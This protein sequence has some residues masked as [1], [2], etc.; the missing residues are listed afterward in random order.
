MPPWWI[1]KPPNGR[2]LGLP[3]AI[4]S[5]DVDVSSAYWTTIATTT[6]FARPQQVQ[7]ILNDKMVCQQ[8]HGI[9]LL[10]VVKRPMYHANPNGITVNLYGFKNVGRG[11][12]LLCAP[13]RQTSRIDRFDVR[14]R[15]IDRRWA[16]LFIR[17]ATTPH[18]FV[19][20]LG[21]N[22][23]Q[24]LAYFYHPRKQITP[25]GEISAGTAA[26]WTD[27]CSWY[28]RTG[29]YVWQHH[30]CQWKSTKI[31]MQDTRSCIAV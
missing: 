31:K 22:T 21:R 23:G 15:N 1:S 20:L 18:L 8:T 28:Y 11:I 25:C 7:L 14:W 4:R 10:Q 29:R 13:N 17:G 9:A 12:Q 26:A 24:N 5:F 6:R 16:R 3:T 19:Q 27:Y 30:H 2:G